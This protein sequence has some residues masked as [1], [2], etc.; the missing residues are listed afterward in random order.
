MQMKRPWR[1][2]NATLVTRPRDRVKY[3]G[4]VAHKSTHPLGSTNPKF[5]ITSLSS[6]AT[7]GSKLSIKSSQ[8]F[9]LHSENVN[10]IND[11]N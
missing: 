10:V 7:F 9:R 8:V 3:A 6:A 4:N 1:Q 5:P 2:L 11:A